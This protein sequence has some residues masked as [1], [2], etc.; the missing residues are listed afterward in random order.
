M[1]NIPRRSAPRR[2]G[3]IFRGLLQRR[4]ARQDDLDSRARARRGIESEPSA[5]TGSHDTVDDM[6]TKP[7][8]ALIA[9]G[10]EERIERTAPDIK[11]HAAAIVG[12][13]DL[14]IVL[15]GLPAP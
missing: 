11:G 4:N 1:G 15:A 13:N 9:A 12:K 10:R 6:Q 2:S 5:Q 8:A 3:S 7:G 14:D